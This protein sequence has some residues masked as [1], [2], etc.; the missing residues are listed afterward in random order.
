[1]SR[2]DSLHARLVVSGPLGFRAPQEVIARRISADPTAIAEFIALNHR[3]LARLERRDPAIATDLAWQTEV[4]A[5]LVVAG[6]DPADGEF[7]WLGM[8]EL[9][10]P[11][12]PAR[13]GASDDW[14]ITV[15][16][17][18]ALESDP[19]PFNA[20]G[21]NENL[22]KEWRIVYADHLQL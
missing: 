4:V 21:Q 2:P 16:E 13:P 6:F 3:F 11:I 18:E 17:W 10:E 15:E 9:P 1:L 19:I 22:S 5:E 7:A 8:L 20:A 12:D 14:R